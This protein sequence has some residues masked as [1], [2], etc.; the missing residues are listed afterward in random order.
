MLANDPLRESLGLALAYIDGDD[1][2]VAEILARYSLAGDDLGL[3][4][5]VLDL[6][7]LGRDEDELAELLYGVALVGV[8]QPPSRDV[9]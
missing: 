3:L 4:V 8:A 9:P 7:T 2:L 6:L 5:S 1:E